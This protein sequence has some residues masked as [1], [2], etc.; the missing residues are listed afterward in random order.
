M[1]RDGELWRFSR[2]RQGPQQ[3]LSRFT[4]GSNGLSGLGPGFGRL[5]TA[6][7]TSAGFEVMAMIRMGQVRG[8]T[9]SHGNLL[10]L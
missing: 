5:Q 6:E 2:L 7:R 3:S 8:P 4:G 9:A 10:R 1:K